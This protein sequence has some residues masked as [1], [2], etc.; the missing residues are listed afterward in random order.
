MRNY[1]AWMMTTVSEQLRLPTGDLLELGDYSEWRRI[2]LSECRGLLR[3]LSRFTPCHPYDISLAQ[4]LQSANTNLF[5][6]WWPDEDDASL[7]D[8]RRRD[9]NRIGP[10]PILI[11]MRYAEQ[12]E[13][14][15]IIVPISRSCGGYTVEHSVK[16]PYDTKPHSMTNRVSIFVDIFAEGVD[17]KGGA[18]S[19]FN[20]IYCKAQFTFLSCQIETIRS[21]NMR[22][23]Q[24][25][26]GEDKAFMEGVIQRMKGKSA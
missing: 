24:Q 18:Y 9:P 5:R 19:V 2:R 14:D 26:S 25:I 7:E 8:I 1:A 10:R 12:M 4:R 23:L 11:P 17:E 13:H 21:L 3:R 20:C 6:F 22:L 16:C 15:D